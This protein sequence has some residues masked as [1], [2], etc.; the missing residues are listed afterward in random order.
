M[1]QTLLFFLLLPLNTLAAL[2]MAYMYNE[3]GNTDYPEG[4]M[5]YMEWWVSLVDPLDS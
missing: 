1:K 2:A 4:F 3:E 5:D